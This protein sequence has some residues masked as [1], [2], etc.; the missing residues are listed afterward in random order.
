MAIYCALT[1][2]TIT[3]MRRTWELVS[4][5]SRATLDILGG[6]VDVSKN[7]AGLRHQLQNLMPPCLPFV[8]MYL[9]DLTFVDHGNPATRQLATSEGSTPVINFDKHVKT[10]KII[11]DL[12]RFQLPYRLE[13]IPE[14]QTWIQDQLVR[15]RSTGDK[16][17]QKFYRRSL[18]LEPKDVP[19]RRPSPSIHAMPQPVRQETKERFDFLSWTHSSKDK[20]ITTH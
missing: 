8:G 1:N 9:T 15:V 2:S 17:F 3:R 14:L 11:S 10:A 7:Y 5:K 4:P 19:S 13:E 6:I 16:S 18:V 12:Q 20:S